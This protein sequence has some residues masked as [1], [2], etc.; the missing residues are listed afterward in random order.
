MLTNTS[1]LDQVQPG[2]LLEHGQ[3]QRQAVLI[4]ADRHP[5]GHAVRRRAGKRL[6]FDE[7]R[8]RTFDRAEHRRSRRRDRPLGEKERRRIGTGLEAA[9]GHLEHA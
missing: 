7:D 3:E 1:S 4:D 9:A 8:P 6:H 5:L 2:A